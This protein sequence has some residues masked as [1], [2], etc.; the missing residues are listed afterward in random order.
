MRLDYLPILDVDQERKLQWLV[1]HAS[2]MFTAHEH[3]LR[4]EPAISSPEEVRSQLGF[5]DSLFSILMHFTGLQGGLEHIF[6][7]SDPR[8]GGVQILLFVSSLRLDLS[9]R[10]VVLDAAALPLQDD[11]MPQITDFLQALTYRGFCT[12]VADEAELRHALPAWV[13]RCRN[14]GLVLIY[15][16][17]TSTSVLTLE[18]SPGLTQSKPLLCQ[19]HCF[20]GHSLPMLAILVR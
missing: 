2:S 13:E 9:N 19:R 3:R 1:I 4:G 12:I 8:G 20:W 18:S 5:K 11:L 16:R 15:R 7:I 17:M 6:S 10:T 14:L